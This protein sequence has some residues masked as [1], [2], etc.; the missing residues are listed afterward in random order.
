MI[1]WQCCYVIKEVW[2][3]LSREIILKTGDEYQHPHTDH[4]LPVKHL[5]G[6]HIVIDGMIPIGVFTIQ[7]LYRFNAF[8][9][10]IILI[11]RILS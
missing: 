5:I 1:G 9:Q 4:M 8:N 10:V 11:V 3:R 7:K 2:S 6:Y